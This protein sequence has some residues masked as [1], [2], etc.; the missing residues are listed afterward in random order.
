MSTALTTKIA[1]YSPDIS[2]MFDQ[3]F[4]NGTPPTNTGSQSL[5]SLWTYYPNGISTIDPGPMTGQKSWRFNNANSNTAGLRNTVGGYS[6]E[7]YF[8]STT[9]FTVGIWIK[10]RYFNQS[11]LT[12]ACRLLNNTTSA[13]NN[14]AYWNGFYIGMGYDPGQQKNGFDFYTGGTD[15]FVTSDENGNNIVTNKWYY[16][17][18]RRYYTNN[19][20]T[21]VTECYINGALKE[22]ISVSASIQSLSYLWFGNAQLN[23][24]DYELAGFHVARPS[25]LTQTALQEIYQV[26]AGVNTSVSATPS[27]AS[28]DI[29]ASTV[30]LGATHTQSALTATAL[31]TEPTV[32][33]VIGDHVEVTTSIPVSA[34]LLT[35]ITAGAETNINNVISET[36]NA[37]AIFGDNATAITGS[38]ISISA[39]EMTASAL[40]NT[41]RMSEIA[42]VATALMPEATVFVTPNYYSLVKSHNPVFYT[43]LDESTIT[44]FGSWTDLTYEVKSGVSKNV[45][46][47]SSMGLIGAGKSWKFTDTTYASTNDI[48]V[49][50]LSIDP[51][52]NLI[53]SRNYTMEMWVYLDSELES[54]G[55]AIMEMGNTRFGVTSYRRNS[56]QYNDLYIYVNDLVNSFTGYYDNGG[57]AIYGQDYEARLST[58]GLINRL[59]WNHLVCRVTPG[60]NTNES[61]YQIFINGSL[62]TSFTR[63]L[64]TSLPNSVNYKTL[65]LW[66][67]DNVYLL[68]QSTGYGAGAAGAKI[69]EVAVYPITLSNSQ[70]IDNYSFI[71]NQNPN[72]TIA[73]SPLMVTATF[74]SHNFFAEVNT[75]VFATSLTSSL[76][77][78]NPSILAQKTINYSATSLTA[79]AQ[80]TDVTVY[81]GWTINATPAIAYGEIAPSYFL[82]S[83]Y[84]DYV[85]TN[86]APYRYVTFDTANASTDFGI[87]NDYS[88]TP[89]TI[90]GTVVN[91]DLGING[92]SVKTTGNSYITD[93]VI[94]N[95]SE[96]N[97]SWGTGQNSYHSAFWFQRAL[98]DASTT[99]LRV[100]WNL[101]GYKDNQHVVLYQYQGKLHMQFNNG[102]GTWIEQDTTNGIDLFDY[103]RHFVVIE[104]DHSN[105]NNNTVRLYVDAVLKMTVN[106]GTYTGSTTNA[107]SA[108]SGPNYEANNHPRL[109]IGCLITPFASTALPVVPT[110]TK[111]II[112][113][114]YWDKNSISSTMVTNLYNIMPDKVNVSVVAIPLTA[115]DELVNPTIITNSIISVNAMTSN[116]LLVD[117]TLYLVRI[118]SISANTLTAS[119]LINNA[120]FAQNV[121]IV[122][123]IMITTATFNNAG[124]II[125]IPGGP[126][127]AS[128]ELLDRPYQGIYISTDIIV[129]RGF[130]A[131]RFSTSYF[132]TL[133][134]W[135]AWLRSTD[136]GKLVPTRE[137]K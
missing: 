95:E 6:A 55:T 54:D 88:V 67:G 26:V 41:A 51:V 72:R 93:G 57:Y 52:K 39:I 109:S 21:M 7:T 124:A 130:S 45:A 77:I 119:A 42:L 100:L 79:S 133:S 126:M 43:N 116:T 102:S 135:A 37:S 101:N 136:S 63:T 82:N 46:S 94:L 76:D 90:G 35:N 8:N 81:W 96:W 89:T 129:G 12:G 84:Y 50:A 34:E 105:V 24:M 13:P 75:T 111:L 98:D 69:D 48:R 117:P 91:P 73:T 122:S 4:A 49:N 31:Q 121:I 92:K 16:L 32:V 1:S 104:F 38:D 131:Q 22:T 87:D 3:T 86:I 2:L 27:T 99:G 118:V 70:I 62:L 85:Q 30:K 78:V 112:D 68:S 29:V 19:N 56:V 18:I 114:V 9:G 58:S 115:S 97:D 5:S 20:A 125:S 120:T 71:H 110:N 40:I 74:G 53:L 17:A 64:N 113:E 10:P 25:V 132:Y 44:N 15:K 14:D 28:A 11:V 107:S 66:D 65:H 60:S 33:A 128:L 36:L 47:G 59:D 127:V 106:L 123:D 134:K 80:N 23:L 137:I 103:E 108:D 61:F 83:T